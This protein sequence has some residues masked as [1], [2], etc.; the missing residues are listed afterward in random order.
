MLVS[1]ITALGPGDIPAVAWPL[2][3]LYR[4]YEQRLLREVRAKPMPRHIGII[5]DGNRR[6]G[7]ERGIS[8]ARTIYGLGADKL[9]EVL[10][11]CADLQIPAVTL[12]A[13]STDNGRRSPHEVSGILSAIEEKL[14]RLARDPQIHRRRVRVRAVGRI[15]GLPDALKA[16]VEEAERATSGFEGTCLTIAVA[17]GGRDEIVDAMRAW[18][19][20]RAAAGESLEQAISDLS[21]EAI[22]RHLYAADLPD[23]DLIIR[24]SGEVR[25]SGFLLWQSVYSEFYFSDVYWP[26]LRKVDFLRAIRSFQ[27]RERRY[28]T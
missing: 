26:A 2:R 21:A 20:G 28:G 14:R 4:L 15:G 23:P 16:A 6:F 22:G 19:S 27:Q 1:R 18:L 9:D 8:D 10:D 13:Y 17:Y 12:W 24:T 7:E 5:L 25:L 11:W 3:L